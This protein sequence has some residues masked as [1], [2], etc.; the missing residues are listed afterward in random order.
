M[1]AAEEGCWL[2]GQLPDSTREGN[3]EMAPGIGAS[4]LGFEPR[5]ELAR[6]TSLASGWQGVMVAQVSRYPCNIMQ[7]EDG[8]GRGSAEDRVSSQGLF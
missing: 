2:P 7:G 5:E 3:L 4:G 8:G 1:K 6:Q